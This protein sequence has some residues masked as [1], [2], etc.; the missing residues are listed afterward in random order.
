MMQLTSL[1]H[2][3]CFADIDECAESYHRCHVQ[4]SCHNNLGSYFCKCLVNWVGDGFTCKRNYDFFR[5]I[6][7]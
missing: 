7:I 3:V 4:S 5:F 6:K 1:L 2:F